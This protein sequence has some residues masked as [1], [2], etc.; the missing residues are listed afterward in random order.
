MVTARESGFVTV[1]LRRLILREQRA[2]QRARSGSPTEML[3]VCVGSEAPPAVMSTEIPTCDAAT[4]R[5]RRGRLRPECNEIL[6]LPLHR[7][8]FLRSRGLRHTVP[9]HTAR[10]AY[11]GYRPAPTRSESSSSHDAPV[12]HSR[13]PSTS[14]DGQTAP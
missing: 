8:E 3:A 1:S 9:A 4:A 11:L 12:G 14:P 7:V 2:A 10:R 13:G 6:E 5:P